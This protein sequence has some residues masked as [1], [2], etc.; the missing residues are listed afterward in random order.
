MFIKSKKVKNLEHELQEASNSYYNTDTPIMSDQEYDLKLEKL[1]ALEEKYEIP[2]E[3]RVSNKVGYPVLD[4]LEKIII[5]PRPMLSLDKCHTAQELKDFCKDQP[6]F[7]SLK[8]DGVSVRLKYR[9]GKLYSANTRGDGE[10]GSDITE[11]V[12]AF[13]NTP[14][15]INALGEY[16]IDGEA[17]IKYHDFDK[18]N[19]NNEFKNPRNTVAGSLNLLDLNTVRERMITFI[20]WE[21]ITP[22]PGQSKTDALRAA[23][24]MGFSVVPYLLPDLH[25]NDIDGV[26]K[27]IR[28]S[29]KDIPNDGVVWKFNDYAYAESLGGTGHHFRD[30]IAWKPE[31]ETVE[32]RLKDIHWTMGR[33]G[34]LTP[35]AVFEPVEL[36]GSTIERASLHNYSVLRKTLGPCAYVGEKVKI[37]KANMIIPQILEGGPHYGYDEIIAAGGVSAH[38]VIEQCPVCGGDVALE[39]SLDGVMNFV[40]TNPTC[41]GKLV[42]RL[43]HYCGKKGLDIKGLSEATLEKLIDW[44]WIENL[45]DIYLLE[46]HRDDWIKKP[47]FGAKSVDKILTAITTSRNTTLDAYISAIGIPLVGRNTAKELV[48][49]FKTYTEF[50]DAVK[51]DSYHFFKLDNFGIEIDYSIKHFDYTEADEIAKILT[52]DE[53]NPQEEQ[54]NSSLAGQTFVITGSLKTYKNRAALQKDIEVKGGKVGSSITSKTTYLINND[55]DS[56]SSKNQRAK[57]LGVPIIT[58][59]EFISNFLH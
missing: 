9:D 43:D 27:E 53:N 19:K 48:K 26:N 46:D 35:V 33:T 4:K 54:K 42:N 40:C 50:K 7:A 11:H 56:A 1:K 8:C 58:E 36:D 30:G 14:I 2:E 25:I 6:V 21:V 23:A 5:T 3:K 34:V 39:T 16:I 17:V 41:S 49:H 51:D 28:N 47:G 13:F 22:E 20:A 12:K 44:G 37:F 10:V 31:I 29:N 18:I 32:S 52:F 38:D 24:G 55:I 59:E 15:K 57:Q 45:K